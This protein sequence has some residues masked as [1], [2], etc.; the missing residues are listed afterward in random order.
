MFRKEQNNAKNPMKVF[1]CLKSPI[2]LAVTSTLVKN[3]P[4]QPGIHTFSNSVF[5]YSENHNYHVVRSLAGS[6]QALNVAFE[7]SSTGAG[8]EIASQKHLLN[9]SLHSFTF[10][11]SQHLTSSGPFF[12][13]KHARLSAH[14][15]GGKSDGRVIQHL[16]GPSCMCFTKFGELPTVTSPSKHTRLLQKAPFPESSSTSPDN[17]RMVPVEIHSC[18]SNQEK[19][20]HPGGILDGAYDS[21]RS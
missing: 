14:F 20:T 19:L 3:S 7:A 21:L 4:S 18:F 11:T 9:H 2:P 13:N 12:A 16:A 17:P 15:F 6:H 10:T 1:R 5:R 8:G